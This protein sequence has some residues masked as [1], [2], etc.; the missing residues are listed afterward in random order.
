M[1]SSGGVSPLFL[2]LKENGPARNRHN[3][4]PLKQLSFSSVKLKVLAVIRWVVM[5]WIKSDTAAGFTTR[6]T[7]VKKLKI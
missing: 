6:K 7:A 4:K 5:T 2:D 3:G 1:V